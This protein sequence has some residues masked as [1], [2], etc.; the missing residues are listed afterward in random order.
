[1]G[2]LAA[3][4]GLTEERALDPD[5]FFSLENVNG[6]VTVSTWNEPRVRIEAEKSA[7]SESRLRQLR[8]EIEGQ[9]HEVSVRTRLPGSWLF[10]GSGMVEYR[11]TV[12]SGARVRLTTVNGSVDVRDVTGELR[13]STVN[14][15]LEVADVSGNV[16][17]TTVNGRI[18]ARYRSTNTN[19]RNRFSTTN[20]SIDISVP[21]GAGGTFEARTVNGRV[22]CD[23]PL[24]STRRSDRHYLEGRLGKGTGSFEL[25]TIN[26]SIRLERS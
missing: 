21:E 19:G 26:G 23:V 8:V 10:G 14:G 12:P 17:A 4:E 20:G 11:I 2:R 5:G 6:R 13:A 25:S 16:D 18:R 22:H 9:G 24:E 7:I 3:R 1:M 15:S